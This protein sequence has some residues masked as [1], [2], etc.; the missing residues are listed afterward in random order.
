M[1]G[2]GCPLSITYEQKRQILDYMSQPG[3]WGNHFDMNFFTDERRKWRT[4]TQNNVSVSTNADRR[5][6]FLED[7]K[8]GASLLLIVEKDNTRIITDESGCVVKVD[9][10]SKISTS[11]DAEITNLET[12][13]EIGLNQPGSRIVTIPEL[14]CYARF[15]NNGGKAVFLDDRGARISLPPPK[16]AKAATMH[17]GRFFHVVSFDLETAASWGMTP[18]GL[19]NGAKLI[20]SKDLSIEPDL[21]AFNELDP[22]KA[23]E[24][25]EYMM[26]DEYDTTFKG[27]WQWRP[28]LPKQLRNADDL[29]KK[30]T[31]IKEFDGHLIATPRQFHVETTDSGFN[32]GTSLDHRETIWAQAAVLKAASSGHIVPVETVSSHFAPRTLMHLLQNSQALP[33][34]RGRSW[35]YVV[36]HAKQTAGMALEARKIG[37]EHFGLTGYHFAALNFDDQTCLVAMDT[38][39]LEKLSRS[40]DA[41]I[42]MLHMI[43]SRNTDAAKMK[44]LLEAGADLRFVNPEEVAKGRTFANEMVQADNFELLAELR[45]YGGV[46]DLSPIDEEQP[47]EPQGPMM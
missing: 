25:L 47:P 20:V 14:S 45:D 27:P 31:D 35:N 5:S 32:I 41:T 28:K 9:A 29:R 21:K 24:Y 22:E 33:D 6:F 19:L 3:H 44:E 39:V 43:K 13:Y 8:T 36:I 34:H 30:W 37:R 17:M 38:E 23:A 12:A 26:R 16:D 40:Y 7:Q 18:Y 11:K 1:N 2:S 4:T 42:E 15:Y 46:H 10:T